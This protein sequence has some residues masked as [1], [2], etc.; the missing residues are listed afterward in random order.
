M[1]VGKVRIYPRSPLRVPTGEDVPCVKCNS[2]RILQMER[3]PRKLGRAS[4]V[5]NGFVRMSS[6]NIGAEAV[7]FGY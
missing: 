2:F 7:P 4:Y 5:V 1:T 6:H 3:P